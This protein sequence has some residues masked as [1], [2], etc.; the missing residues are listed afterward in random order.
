MMFDIAGSRIRSGEVRA[1]AVTGASWHQDI[2]EVQTM[3]EVGL[4][5]MTSTS[6]TGLMG[7]AGTPRDVVVL[8]NGMLN[9]LIKV[10][11]VQSKMKALGLMPAGGTPEEFGAWANEQRQ[12]WIRVVKQAGIQSTN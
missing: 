10:P 12:K 4:P 8:P 3:A 2:P 5:A 7:P 6:G 1:L 11:D 9:E